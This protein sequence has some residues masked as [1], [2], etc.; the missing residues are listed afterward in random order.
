MTQISGI[1]VK[2]LRT[3]Y[4]IEP[5][6]KLKPI[7]IL[8]GKNSA[9]KSTFARILPLLRQ[10]AE[11]RKR[12]PILWF[13]DLVDFGTFSQAVT[14]G[15]NTIHIV[16]Q[17][18][19]IIERAKY[20]YGGSQSPIFL[21][22]IEITLEL[23]SEAEITYAS[24]ISIKTAGTEI[25]LEM[26]T[27]GKFGQILI[28][29]N[30]Y[31]LSEKN[32]IIIEQGA[33][34]PRIKFLE[35]R[36][37]DTK[38]AWYYSKNP[39]ASELQDY[40]HGILHQNTSKE[41]SDQITRKIPIGDPHI[42][43]EELRKID[44][45]KKWKELRSLS[46]KINSP[47]LINRIIEKSIISNI[48]LII[49]KI[50]D[51]IASSVKGIRYIKPI[52]ANAERYYRRADLSVSEIDPDGRNLPIFLDSL[53]PAQLNNFRIWLKEN[54]GIDAFT[55]RDGAQIVLQAQ[56]DTDSGV[57]NVAD[58][59]FGISQILPVAA[60]LW[61]SVELK[62]R[63]LTETSIIVIEQPELHLHPEFQAKIANVLV[64]TV[65]NK[66]KTSPKLIIETH[67]QHLINR[68]GLLIEEKKIS[69]EN[70][71]LVIFEPNPKKPGTSSIRIANFNE[72]GVLE[73][74]PFGFF[75]PMI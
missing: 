55:K 18:D 12:S 35:K 31:L 29:G 34:L 73:N 23:L 59:G 40:I 70:V 9:G 45:P 2:N 14:R 69:H 33:I 53:T 7:T 50:D 38:E 27:P 65:S 43:H 44:G 16:I 47:I 75:E 41:T 13:D 71:S 5:S 52:R 26:P 61:A 74:W 17:I 19:S 48:D 64:G 51:S 25:K 67:S 66:H 21:S 72:D 20:F 10:S 6:I 60:Q 15:E 30:P 36:R 57:S 24:S 8:L 3:L 22:N 46:D 28:G 58:M 11:R 63:Y 32:Q 37:I 42:L 49:D 54:L 4:S 62:N 39:W 1:G 56:S 68:L